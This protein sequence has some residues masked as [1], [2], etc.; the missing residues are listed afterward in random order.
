MPP[1]CSISV[2]YVDAAVEITRAFAEA[3]ALVLGQPRVQ[4]KAGTLTGAETMNTA[5][6]AS[7][8]C[9]YHP[10]ADPAAETVDVSSCCCTPW[11]AAPSSASTLTPSPAASDH[12]PTPP[13]LT[14]PNHTPPSH[15]PLATHITHYPQLTI[16]LA[17]V[18]ARED[19]E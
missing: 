4:R 1:R 11:V 17:I 15:T 9:Q 6:A 18:R 8:V 13:H 19:A 5:V 10:A 16:H 14:P 3:D 7:E 12:A 2:Y